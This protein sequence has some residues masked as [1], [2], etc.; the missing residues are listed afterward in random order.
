MLEALKSMQNHI[1][2]THIIG[3]VFDGMNLTDNDEHIYLM[4]EM[5]EGKVLTVLEAGIATSNAAQA[6]AG[7]CQK[8]HP[9][10]RLGRRRNNPHILREAICSQKWCSKISHYQ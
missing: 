2:W 6:T 8:S 5:Y 7:S 9:C 3:E 10:R 4:K 1:T